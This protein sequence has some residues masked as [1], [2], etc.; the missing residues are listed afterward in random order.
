MRSKTI[1][2]M[3][4]NNAL[5]T[6][7]MLASYLNEQRVDYLDMI[8]PFVLRTLPEQANSIID[9]PNVVKKIND[10]YG[11]NVNQK[12]I[13]KIL[14]RLCKNKN[15]NVIRKENQR[16]GSLRQTES[17]RRYYVNQ[18]INYE[19]FDNRK[20][21]IK[22]SVEEVVNKLK[23]FINDNYQCLVPIK[24]GQAQ[25]CF[26]TFLKNY[27]Y[28]LYS[29]VD[30]LR[31]IQGIEKSNSDNFR[32][33]KFILHE[34]ALKEDGCYNKIKEIQEGFFASTAIY[35]FC[36][37]VKSDNPKKIIDKTKVF[38]DTRLLIDVLGLNQ[39]SES[40]SMRELI[41]LVKK[42][43]GQLCTFDYYVDEL[44]GIINRYLKDKNSRYLLD[45]DFFRRGE[46]SNAEISLRKLTIERDLIDENI[47]IISD[48]DFDEQI[49]DQTWHIDSLELK[50]NMSSLINYSGGECAPAF[51]NDLRTLERISF[52]K[53]NSVK[54][55]TQKAIFVTSNYGIIKAAESTFTD[56]IFQD[57]I[58]IVISDI[59]LVAAL[60]LSNYN[61]SSE[62]SSLI[63]LENAY[64]AI[65]PDKKILTEVMGIIERSMNDS[66]EKI[67]EEALL[68]RSNKYLIE[69]IAEVT[70]NEKAD[71]DNGILHK[72][73]ERME[74]RIYDEAFDEVYD[75]AYS[76]AYVDAK[77]KL[78]AEIRG[79]VAKEYEQRVSDVNI[80]E[81]NAKMLKEE[82][83]EKSKEADLKSQES[84]EVQER[85]QQ[86][87]E[88]LNIVNDENR[89]LREENQQMRR[90]EE[91]KCGRLAK[92]VA[93]S[94]KLI[95]Y[96][97]LLILCWYV[98]S[99]IVIDL[100][101]SVIEKFFDIREEKLVNN[102]ITIIGTILTFAPVVV[103]IKKMI[104]KISNKIFDRAYHFLYNRSAI[105]KLNK[106]VNK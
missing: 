50:R 40:K 89:Q 1:V 76:K 80:Q 3:K 35:Y 4:H 79:E 86:K 47:E 26:L 51:Q 29:N 65:Y 19:E 25:E 93:N 66:D 83:E 6:K 33:A 90:I 44:I 77:Q 41:S 43:G 99:K 17:T 45:L 23:N 75:E 30:N 100:F 74:D 39:E 38:L 59:D 56:P 104:D 84:Q 54:K 96:V 27:N 62:L 7:A 21:K 69:D 94:F 92:C 9:V 42:N 78:D 49:K 53:S 67:K 18:K 60:W 85:Y 10:E 87:S 36:N 88:E 22:Q 46:C 91:Q 57:D 52:Y 102:V 15:G 5:I 105:L 82:A 61:P 14:T 103:T 71:F 12:I 106:S 98:V 34:Y 8:S 58:G 95:C 2:D 101:G 32:V 13:E 55:H 72:L 11:L 28:E 16:T 81:I 64:A 31:E 97:L 68:L 73:F 24:Y 37:S 63:L 20:K 48:V 70:Q